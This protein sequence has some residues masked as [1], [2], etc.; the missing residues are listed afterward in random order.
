MKKD[1]MQQ[2]NEVWAKEEQKGKELGFNTLEEYRTWKANEN[3][4]KTYLAKIAHYEK[5]IEDMKK[6]LAE[7]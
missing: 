7:H 4:K 5:A 1:L 3:R 6:W 2:Q